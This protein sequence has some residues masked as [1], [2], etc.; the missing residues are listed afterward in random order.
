MFTKGVAVGLRDAHL[1][2]VSA[3]RLDDTPKGCSMEQSTLKV[4]AKS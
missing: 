2:E 1:R 3:Q 4:V